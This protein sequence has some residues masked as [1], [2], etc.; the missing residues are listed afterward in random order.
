MIKQILSEI[1]TVIQGKEK[2]IKL[3]LAAFLAKGHILIEDIPGVG[4]TTLAKTVA[5]VLGL[6]F[7]R[8]QFTSDLLP[9][10][11]LGVNYFDTKA[12]LFIFKKGPIFSEFILADEIN[13]ATPKTQSALLEAMEENQ[14][15]IEGKSMALPH[16]FFVIA[17]QNPVEESGTFLLPHSQIDRFM[18][19]LSL[20]YPDQ[21]AEKSI[22]LR[23]SQPKSPKSFEKEAVIS[24]QKSVSNIHVSE[25]LV[26]YILFILEFTRQSGLFEYGISTRG[27]LALIEISKAWA[28]I[29]GRDYVIDDDVSEVLPYVISHRLQA[30]NNHI[31]ALDEI[32]KHV[33]RL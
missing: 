15:T 31:N 24:L 1:E 19:S 29:Q 9:S 3:S 22:L 12:S 20:G 8:I 28:F 27:A 25:N 5:T 11:I 2:Q 30:K 13:R 6:H 14:V 4:K 7:N 17:T 33:N 23:S 26:H 21:E 10:D 32:Y 18:I 16:P